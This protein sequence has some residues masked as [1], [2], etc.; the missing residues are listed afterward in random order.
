M[1]SSKCGILHACEDRWREANFD[2]HD[3]LGQPH[4]TEAQPPTFCSVALEEALGHVLAG[5]LV[6]ELKMS[7][8]ELQVGGRSQTKSRCV[9]QALDER[10]VQGALVVSKVV[11]LFMLRGL[12][13]VEVPADQG[14]V[15]VAWLHGV[16]NLEDE[17]LVGVIHKDS[18]R[19]HIPGSV[20][21]QRASNRLR[22]VNLRWPLLL[23]VEL[24]L[25]ELPQACQQFGID[26]GALDGMEVGEK[27]LQ[28]LVDVAGALLCQGKG[29]EDEGSCDGLLRVEGIR[30]RE[31]LSHEQSLQAAR[32]IV[33][34][35]IPDVGLR[36]LLV[37]MLQRQ[38][39]KHDPHLWGATSSHS[40][41]ATEVAQLLGVGWHVQILR[42][43]WARLLGC[44]GNVVE[45]LVG[46]RQLL[47]R[48]PVAN[49]DQVQ[50]SG[51][52][53]I[54]VKG[55]QGL[56]QVLP[57][58]LRDRLQ[59]AQITGREFVH[60]V[61]RVGLRPQQVPETMLRI[62]LI[63]LVLRIHG[64]DLLVHHGWIKRRGNEEL[65]EDVQSTLQALVVD[66]VEIDGLLRRG[67][68][69]VRAAVPCQSGRE[70]VVVGV[71]LRTEEEH[72]LAEVRQ[73]LKIWGVL[74]G[75]GLHSHG[76][77]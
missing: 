31:I 64:I 6:D 25:P 60:G 4:L 20:S 8:D 41:D 11:V 56:R 37:P 15:H 66:L 23:V 35:G 75:P 61:L 73:A 69:V 7:W 72:V 38:H 32:P 17:L 46:N 10:R 39:R 52:I 3:S 58:A 54:T 42:P 68:C 27:I 43:R 49:H 47:R 30:L 26:A 55:P 14:N 53:A 19:Q 12:L 44:L 33:T 74:Q 28:D 70:G 16:E 59:G 1:H 48:A 50:P 18:T 13:L 57:L 76:K 77:A 65:G 36:Q 67:V 9:L 22:K 45:V 29:H 24:H 34:Q 51:A 5:R 40:K 63:L 21:W 2:G 71:L 62:W